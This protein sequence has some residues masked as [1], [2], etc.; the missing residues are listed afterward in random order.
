MAEKKKISPEVN[1]ARVRA[2]MEHRDR[3]NVYL[4]EGT[5]DRITALGFKGSAFAKKLILEE[6]E[7]LERIQKESPPE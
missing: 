2:T 3:L 5:V 6:L 7:K 4:P 1:R